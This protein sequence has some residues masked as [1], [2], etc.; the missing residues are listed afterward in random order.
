M[1]S[2]KYPAL[3]PCYNRL[4]VA[5]ERGEGVYLY[6]KNNK[7][8][9]DFAGGIAVASLGHCHPHLV[10]SL[11]KQAGLLWHTSNMYEIPSQERLAERLVEASFA[12]SVFFTNSGVEAVECALKLARKAQS[13]TGHPERYRVI[14][15]H[16]AF[17]GRSLATISATGREKL[18]KGF[19]PMLEGFDQVNFL[20]IEA[21]R[22]AITPET[23]AIMIEPVQGEGGILVASPE[24]LQA[25][26]ALAD[27]HELLL[28]FDEIQCG[29]GRSGKLFAFEWTGIV[30]DILA[31]AKGI[32]SGFPL[33]ACLA[34]GSVAQHLTTG[35]HGTTYGGN[36]L[37]M[38]VGNSVMDIMLENGFFAEVQDNAKYLREGL[39]AL[40]QKYPEIIVDVRG[41][42]MMLGVELSCEARP[43]LEGLLEEGF[44]CAQAGT[45]VLRFL[46]PLI[47]TKPDV[48]KAIAF[49]EKAVVRLQANN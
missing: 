10:Q 42:G 27:E 7:E 43:V 18:T 13:S 30:P 19:G 9:L 38:A 14:T 32:G 21:T 46:P 45:N 37:A 15:Y 31:S 3:M 36:P 34:K 20:D 48:D 39:E 26:R 12:D 44:L 16:N 29:M 1:I 17:H 24:K 40:K 22:A 8:Y 49:L 28:I 23:A 33:G 11:Q 6:D 35:S 5:F 41:L 47:I 25:L 4:P 2:N